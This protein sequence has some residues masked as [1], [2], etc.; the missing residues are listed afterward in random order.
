ICLTAWSAYAQTGVGQIQGTVLDATGAVVP[1]A[2]VEAVNV[3]TASSFKIVSSDVGFF[4][5]P[6]LQPGDYRVTVSLTGMNSWQGELQLRVSQ[7]AVLSPVLQVRQATEEITVVGDVTPLVATTS[8]TVATVVERERIDQLPLNGRS[9]QTL[10]TITVPG[11]E[12]SSSQPKVYGLRDSAMDIVQDGVGL[13]DRNTGA[14]QSRPPG[15]DTVQEFR[16]ETSVS[17]A[18]LDRPASAIMITRSGTNDLHGSLFLTG[19]NSGFG[20]ARQRQDTF[21]KAPHLVRN[22]FGA[23]VGGP[24]ILPKAYNGKNRT[25]FFASWEEVRNRQASTTT[26]AVWTEAMRRGDFSGLVDG[27]NRKI[28]LYDPWSVG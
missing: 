20:V 14:I 10:L 1:G 21:T 6:S 9:I 25:F 16:V 11:L 13:Q 26:S 22:E 28:T 8:P 7:T 15:L 17:S 19:R 2:T 24:V 23:S 4:L 5:I 27:Q 3:Q 18:K 12:G